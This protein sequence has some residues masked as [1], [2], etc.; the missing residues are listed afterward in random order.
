[1][2]SRIAGTAGSPR[3]ADVP[4]PGTLSSPVRPGTRGMGHAPVLRR[5][6]QGL[7]FLPGPAVPAD[8]VGSVNG[9]LPYPFTAPV[10]PDT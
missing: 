7:P 10:M 4:M 1:M 9:M 6:V 8:E 5:P 3:P 2:F